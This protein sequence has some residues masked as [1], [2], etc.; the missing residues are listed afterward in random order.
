[1]S[2]DWS[3]V[4]RS[5]GGVFDPRTSYDRTGAHDVGVSQ[6]RKLTV[7]TGDGA[8]PLESAI[9]FLE[10]GSAA[11]MTI[12]APTL[13]GKHVDGIEITIVAGTSVAHVVTGT[14]LFWGGA[15]GGPF[16]LITTA[17]F[18]GS[19]ATIVSRKGLWLVTANVLA[20]VG[21]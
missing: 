8:I 11:A 21:D 10:K 16:N 4:T 1:M 3:R 7:K 6:I 13:N 14:N 2:L 17:A 5:L 19:S 9:V 15:T 18:I 12:Q 20:T